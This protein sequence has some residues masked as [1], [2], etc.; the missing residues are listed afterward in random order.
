MFRKGFIE[1]DTITWLH[2]P[3]NEDFEVVLPQVERIRIGWL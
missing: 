2:L 3:R 1:E